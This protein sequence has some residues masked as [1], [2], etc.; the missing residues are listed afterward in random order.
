MFTEH[1]MTVVF[2]I[3]KSITVLHQGA[4]IAEGTPEEVRK[5]E[6][7]IRVYLGEVT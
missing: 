2:G 7:V 6:E 5:N 4:V 3:A 1:D